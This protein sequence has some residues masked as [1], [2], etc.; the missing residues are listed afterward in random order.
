MGNLVNA[1]DGVLQYT[2]RGATHHFNFAEFISNVGIHMFILFAFL[3]SFFFL[4]VEKQLVH[5]FENEITVVA[6][7]QLNGALKAIPADRKKVIAQALKFL[8]MEELARRAQEPDKSVTAH[9]EG[10]KNVAIAVTTGLGALLF[11]SI[12]LVS[13]LTNIDLAIGH[14]LIE[15]VATFAIVGAIEYVFYT[16]IAL[17]YHPAPPSFLG[18]T[19]KESFKA[20][21]D[22]ND[23]K[24][25]AY[26]KAM[27][28]K[29]MAKD[30]AMQQ[31]NQAIDDATFRL[32]QQVNTAVANEVGSLPAQLAMPYINNATNAANAEAKSS[33]SNSIARW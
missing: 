30:F 12:V 29:D 5:V 6:V 33:L 15:N 11:V 8:P 23:S 3:T 1:G 28:A 25:D 17:Q 10:I 22:L 18:T 27:E 21:L 7:N 19:F 20:Q 32:S 2:I 9:N 14:A 4:F 16:Q 13:T 24:F 26:K 31:G